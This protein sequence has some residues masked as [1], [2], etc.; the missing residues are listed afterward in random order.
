MVGYARENPSI[1][2]VCMNGSRTNPIAK[3]DIFQDY[4]IV[5]VVE[6]VSSFVDDKSWLTVSHCRF[7]TRMTCFLKFRTPQARI[8]GTRN[9]RLLISPAAATNSGAS[10]YI[11][12]GLWRREILFTMDHLNTCIRPIIAFGGYQ[13][14]APRRIGNSLI[15]GGTPDKQMPLS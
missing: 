11:A 10:P 14:I 2:A 15:D 4:D 1:R 7:L 8:I 13:E 3:R 9:P 5:Y 6:S 12:K